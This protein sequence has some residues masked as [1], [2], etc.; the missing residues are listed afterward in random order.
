MAPA[1]LH[2]E[3]YGSGP[4]LLILHGLMGPIDGQTYQAG[5]MAPAHALG[6]TR[7]D[8]LSELITYLRFVHGE[9][10][11]SVSPD[12]V[13]ASKSRQPGFMVDGLF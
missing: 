13:K 10:A 11:S 7:E 12:D 5:V 4:P 3:E 6:I 2:F 1:L 9:G 8:R